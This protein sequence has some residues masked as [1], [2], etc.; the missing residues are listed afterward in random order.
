MVHASEF[1][2]K[3]GKSRGV[4]L[5]SDNLFK[6]KKKINQNSI[7]KYSFS[8]SSNIIFIC[9][10]DMPHTY[11][12]YTLYFQDAGCYIENKYIYKNC[13]FFVFFAKISRPNREANAGGVEAK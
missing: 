13:S 2:N 8:S 9:W 3:A 1:Q 10:F 6:L 12:I 11:T 7:K 4:T 5:K